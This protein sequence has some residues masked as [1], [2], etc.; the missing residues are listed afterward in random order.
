MIRAGG[1]RDPGEEVPGGEVETPD[2][3]EPDEIELPDEDV[4]GASRNSGSP[5]EETEVPKPRRSFDLAYIVSFI[6]AGIL[7][8]VLV[9]ARKQAAKSEYY[10]AKPRLCR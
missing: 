8:I 3:E 5:K 4:P 7:P 6:G 10:K 9:L 2:E 1:D